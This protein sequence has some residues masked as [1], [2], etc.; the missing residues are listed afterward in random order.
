MNGQILSRLRNDAWIRPRSTTRGIDGW[1]MCWRPCAELSIRVPAHE[2]RPKRTVTGMACRHVARRD[3]EGETKR[4]M[5]RIA[6]QNP[7]PR[8]VLRGATPVYL[9]ALA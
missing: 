8:S 2:H 9:I 4:S 5:S 3:M 1:A 6:G 7:S